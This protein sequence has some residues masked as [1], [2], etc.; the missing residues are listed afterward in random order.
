MHC[1]CFQIK[2]EK[3]KRNTSY[4]RV[5]EKGLYA[6]QDIFYRISK[7]LFSNCFFLKDR[8]CFMIII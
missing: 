2:R 1:I 4:S 8:E 7:L 5:D 6:S 3:K